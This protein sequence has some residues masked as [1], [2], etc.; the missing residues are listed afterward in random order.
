MRCIHFCGRCEDNTTC[1]YFTPEHERCEAY[2][3]VGEMQKAEQKEREEYQRM[4]KKFEGKHNIL[5]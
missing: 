4:K 5:P 2:G 3:S 1:P